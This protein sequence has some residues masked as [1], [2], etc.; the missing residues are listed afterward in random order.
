MLFLIFIQRW[1]I[2]IDNLILIFKIL[3]A[4]CLQQVLKQQVYEHQHTALPSFVI[5]Y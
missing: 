1:G 4:G 2:L 5:Y 3:F